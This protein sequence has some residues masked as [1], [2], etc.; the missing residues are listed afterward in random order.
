MKLIRVKELKYIENLI[1]KRW[2][3]MVN[4]QYE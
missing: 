4:K 3:F 1:L 2:Y